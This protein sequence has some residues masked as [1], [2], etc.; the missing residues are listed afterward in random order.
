MAILKRK[1]HG[2]VAEQVGTYW[3][4]LTGPGNGLANQLHLAPCNFHFDGPI[5]VGL[6]IDVVYQVAGNHGTWLAFATGDSQ[7]EHLEYENDWPESFTT[8][9]TNT[10]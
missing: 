2:I 8:K 4:V 6:I 10:F 7:V 1:L 3:R 5:H 9:N